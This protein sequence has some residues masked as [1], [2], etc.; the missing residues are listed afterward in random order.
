MF[1]RL[2]TWRPAGAEG[3]HLTAQ[4]LSDKQLVRKHSI[5]LF[6]LWINEYLFCACVMVIFVNFIYFSSIS[7]WVN[8]CLLSHSF[9]FI[10]IIYWVLLQCLHNFNCC[11]QSVLAC[12]N[13]SYFAF[14]TLFPRSQWIFSPALTTSTPSAAPIGLQWRTVDRVST[15]QPQASVRR[16]PKAGPRPVSQSQRL[17]ASVC[18]C[19]CVLTEVFLYVP[20]RSRSSAYS[21][22]CWLNASCSW[23][24]SRLS[25]TSCF[26]PPPVRRKMLRTLQLLRY[27]KNSI[28][29]W[30]VKFLVRTLDATSPWSHL[31]FLIKAN[32]L[33][34]VCLFEAGCCVCSRCPSGD[35]GPGHVSLPDV[36]AAL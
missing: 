12:S 32:N 35:P 22:L 26:F 14:R 13:S 5:T 4:S 9:H 36:R 23:S 31:L 11:V 24:W 6:C 16:A 19:V 34:F 15:A 30:L 25:I 28:T 33:L 1:F 20:Q 18:L 27:K 21:Q 29:E 17:T 7:I 8:I 3:E 10:Y 2:L